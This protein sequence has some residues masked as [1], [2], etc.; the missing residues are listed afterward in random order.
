[1]KYEA[2]TTWKLT[3]F[4]LYRYCYLLLTLTTNYYISKNV[5][6]KYSLLYIS[7]VEYFMPS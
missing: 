5:K 6:H 2:V 7:K 3:K 4:I 1:M